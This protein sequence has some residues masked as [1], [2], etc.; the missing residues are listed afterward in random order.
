M[1]IALCNLIKFNSVY[2]PRACFSEIYFY[3]SSLSRPRDINISLQSIV[4]KVIS[5]IF[6]SFNV[7]SY[8][9]FIPLRFITYKFLL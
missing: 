7:V 6:C 3:V 1:Q 9:S 2:C 8:L 4:S 5:L